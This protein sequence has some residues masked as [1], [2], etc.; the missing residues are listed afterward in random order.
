MIVYVNL[1]ASVRIS[2]Y[3]ELNDTNYRYTTTTTNFLSCEKD[4]NWCQIFW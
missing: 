4:W 2:R 1:H 3:C